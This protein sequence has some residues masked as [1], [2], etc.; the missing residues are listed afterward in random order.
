GIQDSIIRSD[1]MGLPYLHQKAGGSRYP[2]THETIDQRLH[3]V[4]QD[5]QHVFK[6]A[7]TN[8]AEIAA[9]IMERNGLGSADINWLVPHQ[10]NKRIIEATAN[11][12]GVGMEKVKLNIEHYGN[13]TAATIPLCMWDYRTQLNT[14]DNLSH[15]AFGG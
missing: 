1:G 12:M 2:P 8:M 5:G 10:A 9:E 7:V 11:R 13:T 3:Y 6:F 14:A 4:H 15:G